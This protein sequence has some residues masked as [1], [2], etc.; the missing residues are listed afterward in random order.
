MGQGEQEKAV[1]VKSI[2]K[3]RAELTEAGLPE[4][5][6]FALLQLALYVYHNY[7]FS[8][9]DDPEIIKLYEAVQSVDAQI[10]RVVNGARLQ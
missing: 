4:Q 2:D 9:G 7:D 10:E 5:M 6:S 1:S 3:I 8:T